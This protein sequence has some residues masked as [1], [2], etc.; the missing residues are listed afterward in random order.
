MPTRRMNQRE[1]QKNCRKKIYDLP[2][3][4][5]LF[6]VSLLDVYSYRIYDTQKMELQSWL[7][8]QKA[9]KE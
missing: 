7:S 5:G 2:K 6:L 4:K 9:D 1:M 3:Q 8:D